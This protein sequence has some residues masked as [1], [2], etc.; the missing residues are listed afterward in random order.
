MPRA[1]LLVILILLI[2]G[3]VLVAI[4]FISTLQSIAGG[5]P[6]LPLNRKR[7]E[8]AWAAAQLQPGE[9][10]Y[11]LGCGDARQLI[12][13]CRRYSVLGVGVDIAWWPLIG[14]WLRVNFG[15][16]K[17]RVRLI[18]RNMHYI[19]LSPADVVYMYLAQNLSDSLR[20]KF[21][22]E[23]KPGARV[24]SVQFPLTDWMPIS[25]LGSPRYPIY[26]YKI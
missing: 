2:I 7:A 6:F 12:Y 14:A 19:D 1:V 24:I 4:W 5:A 13:A 11:E 26:I 16:M 18:W 22:R 8:E 10:V 25:T 9:T 23:L 21:K 3:L 15:G 17:N 20:D